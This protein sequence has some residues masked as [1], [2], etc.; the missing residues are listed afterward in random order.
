MSV[1]L[2]FKKT[3][4][5]IAYLLVFTILSLNIIGNGALKE[6]NNLSLP[7]P[8]L[9]K[10]TSDLTAFAQ[11]GS[12]RVNPN[13]NPEVN[14]LIKSLAANDLRQPMLIDDQGNH[15]PLVAELFAVRLAKGDVP[16][17]LSGRRL[18]SLDTS[19]LINELKSDAEIGQTF[20]RIINEL[21][22][23]GNEQILFVNYLTNLM[24][25]EQVRETL[26]KTIQTGKLKIIGASGSGKYQE[27]VEAR[28]ETAALFEKIEINARQTQA[29]VEESRKLPSAQREY[30]G[31][32]VA[33]DLREMMQN[34]TSGGRKRLDVILQTKDADNP[35]LREVLTQNNIRL[36][37]RIGDSDTMVVNLPLSA[38]EI[39]AQS[40][41][42]NYISPDRDVK[43]LG[44][45]ETTTGISLM[46][47]QPTGFRT[48]IGLYT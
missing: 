37:D 7:S 15:Q 25:Y 16:N 38:V 43:S 27:T 30:R 31:D 11:Q 42:I 17:N 35:V 33:A 22:L 32:N 47:S 29:N 5:F 23:N 20:E 2:Q 48:F 14:R 12:L 13:F 40:G 21:S 8:T 28:A 34:D 9:S 46:R 4:R 1:Q 45:V 6:H 24:E 36:T 18:F 26:I 10:F 44:H 19:L 41:L 39:L 3:S